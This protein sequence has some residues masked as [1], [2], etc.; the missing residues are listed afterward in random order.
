MRFLPNL[1]RSTALAL[2][3]EGRALAPS[4]SA[5]AHVLVPALKTE[6]YRSPEPAIPVVLG[7]DDSGSMTDGGALAEEQAGFELFAE[8][9]RKD[10]LLAGSLLVSVTGFREVLVPLTPARD[11]YAPKLTAHTDS[12]L[13]ARLVTEIASLS[14][15]GDAIAQHCDRDLRPAMA[16]YFSDGHAGD[17]NRLNE[18]I[19]ATQV[20]AVEARIELYFIGVGTA[21]D[22]PTLERLA[23][24]GR[25]AI[26]MKDVRDFKRFF[27]WLYRSV[28][29]KSQSMMG[30]DVEMPHPFD[31]RKPPLRGEG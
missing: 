30:E 10:R 27:A 28:R 7:A 29:Q 4:P 16:I 22:M 26:H 12:P 20:T 9:V 15:A 5:I 14:R 23:Q 11:F 8:T 6:V 1:S 2:P 3:A 24:P 13:C 19:H 21:C 18:A 31:E 17:L 25:A